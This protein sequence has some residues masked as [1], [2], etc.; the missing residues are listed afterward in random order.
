MDKIVTDETREWDTNWHCWAWRL[1]GKIHRKAGP[2][3]EDGAG[4]KYWFQ[5]GELHREDG[6]A[7]MWGHGRKEWWLNGERLSE[8]EWSQKVKAL[9]EE[10]QCEK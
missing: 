1:N 7:V 8:A 2:A 4:S 9:M 6:P 5:N 10:Q 3:I